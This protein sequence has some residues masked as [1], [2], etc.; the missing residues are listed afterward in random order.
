M[1]TRCMTVMC[2]QYNVRLQYLLIISCFLVLLCS[3]HLF[4]VIII[5]TGF[6][7]TVLF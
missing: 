5:L 4:G 2:I 1:P 7:E 3:Y 6:L